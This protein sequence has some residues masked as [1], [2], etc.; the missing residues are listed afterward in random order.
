LRLLTPGSTTRLDAQLHLL[1]TNLALF[2]A[3]PKTD[4][5]KE[6]SH[7]FSTDKQTERIASDLD[8]YPELRST[9]ENLVPGD[10]DYSSFWT[11]YHF[12]RN[13]LDVEEQK[14]KELLKGAVVDEEEAGWDEDDSEEEDDED[15]DDED[16]GDEDEDDEDEDDDEDDDDESEEES[17]DEKPVTPIRKT[18][19]SKASTDTLQPNPKSKVSMEKSDSEASYDVVSGAPSN[20]PSNSAGSPPKSKA[21]SDDSSD[22][23]EDWE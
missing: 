23:E 5:Y 22:E 2:K 17:E 4:S 18:P 7:S 16:E 6:F 11:R 15:E 19:A 3:D 10:V 8:K 9:M 20:T 14:R 1:H 13:E 21:K 12:L